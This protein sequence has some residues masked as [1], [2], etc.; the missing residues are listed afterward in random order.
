MT[1]SQ[2]AA[3]W[4]TSQPTSRA[5]AGGIGAVSLA[6]GQSRQNGSSAAWRFSSRGEWHWSKSLAKMLSVTFSSH[7][8]VPAATPA[9]SPTSKDGGSAPSNRLSPQDP[10]SLRE[11]A[12]QAD[13]DADEEFHRLEALFQGPLIEKFIQLQISFVGAIAT[14]GPIRLWEAP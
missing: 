5:R 14:P 1:W 7:M 6:A 2:P 8:D 11:V 13:K 9:P 10:E 4:R 12:E 3:R